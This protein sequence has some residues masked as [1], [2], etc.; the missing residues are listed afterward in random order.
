MLRKAIWIACLLLLA[1]IHIGFVQARIVG[2]LV[3]S[4]FEGQAQARLMGVS[5]K[6]PLDG[7]QEI[8]MS[9]VHDDAHGKPDGKALRLDYD[10]DSWEQAK[11]EF[12]IDL[13]QKDLS[14]FDALH[15]YM[16][17]DSE[18]GCTKNV[19][20]KFMDGD[21]GNAPYIVTGIQDR[22]KEFQIPFKRFSRVR[23]WSHMKE[24]GIVFDDVNSNPKEGTLYVDEITVSS[25]ERV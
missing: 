16:R 25:K 8:K 7:N 9:F 12:W 17:G 13:G 22:W 11:A 19:M 18:K 15:F 1:L 4:G 5:V 10:V 3:L 14:A 6:N 20:V 23:D 24:F 2:S 21:N